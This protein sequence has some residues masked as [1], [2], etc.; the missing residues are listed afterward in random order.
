[1]TGFP[2]MC[3]HRYYLLIQI[4]LKKCSVQYDT[5]SMGHV[6]YRNRAVR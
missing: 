3:K 6:V 2:T 1:M 5:E 4:G